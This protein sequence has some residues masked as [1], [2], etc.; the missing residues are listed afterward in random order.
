[1]NDND[2]FN[3]LYSDQDIN[4]GIYYNINTP[5]Q[6]PSDNYSR[7]Q[8]IVGGIGLLYLNNELRR[9]WM[10]HIFWTK[11]TIMSLASDAL[12]IEVVTNRLLKNADDFGNLFAQFYDINF[13]NN[14]AKLMREHLTIALELV[15][16][17]KR[18]DNSSV[19]IIDEKW[20]KNADEISKFLN[21]INPYFSELMVRNMFYNHLALTKDEAVAILNR[22]SNEA[23]ILFDEIEKQALMMSDMF[24]E[25][26]FKQFPN[27]II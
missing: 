27:K 26:L 6:Y 9:L 13:S 7:D 15:L 18:G 17:A 5:Y 22:R 4:G 14:F 2:Y 3:Q 20:H 16:A 19:S 1:M 8:E 21:S 11:I 24:L 25:G 10:E 23:V 12:D